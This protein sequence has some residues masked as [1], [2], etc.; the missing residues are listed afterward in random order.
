MTAIPPE[1][2]ERPLP[3]HALG[4]LSGL[5]GLAIILGLFTYSLMDVL[6][7]GG[8]SA[9]TTGAASSRTTP[10]PIATLAPAATG[11]PVA[12]DPP[13]LLTF[14]LCDGE[15]VVSAIGSG[16]IYHMYVLDLLSETNAVFPPDA[17]VHHSNC[18]RAAVERDDSP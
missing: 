10:Q 7:S 3:H 2:S 9:T 1:S 16:P 13:E 5:A 14:I 15:T 4:L 11:M 6:G 12:S 8:G 17:R 18:A